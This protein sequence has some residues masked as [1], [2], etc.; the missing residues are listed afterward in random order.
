MVAG[1]LALL[2]IMPSDTNG[3]A[4]RSLPFIQQFLSSPYKVLCRVFYYTLSPETSLGYHPYFTDQK[5]DFRENNLFNI[6]KH[7]TGFWTWAFLAEI[8]TLYWCHTF[9][10]LLNSLALLR[11]SISR[12]P[13]FWHVN[14]RWPLLPLNSKALCL[15]FSCSTFWLWH[16]YLIS[17][18]DYERVKREL[19]FIHHSILTS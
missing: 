8:P 1:D 2:I 6:A 11:P 7:R 10:T 19:C 17:K 4:S 15:Y 12:S 3:K 14:Q 9:E 13:T 18:T 5:T 16:I